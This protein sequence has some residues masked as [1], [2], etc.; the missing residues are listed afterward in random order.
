MC[1]KLLAEWDLRAIA[2]SR[3]AE[4]IMHDEWFLDGVSMQIAVSYVMVNVECTGETRLWV[5]RHTG[6]DVRI[7]LHDGFLG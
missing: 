2:D 3:C 6:C 7:L 5:E 4:F 1:P